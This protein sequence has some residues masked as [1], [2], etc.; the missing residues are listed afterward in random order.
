MN[1]LTLKELHDRQNWGFDERGF[2]YKQRYISALEKEI[3]RLKEE[4]GLNDSTTDAG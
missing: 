4:I 2:S 1:E 3:A